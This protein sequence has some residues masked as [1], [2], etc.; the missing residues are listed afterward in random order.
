MNKIYD[1]IDLKKNLKNKKFTLVHGVFDI[2]H[3]GHKRHLDVAS[4]LSDYLVVSIT[5]DKYV[6]KGP[7]RPVFKDVQ[8]AEMIS[9]FSNVDYVYIN[10]DETPIKLINQIKPNVYCKGQDYKNSEDDITGNIKKE[11]NAIKKNGGKVHFT[12]EIQYSSSKII[13]QHLNNSKVL[14]ELKNKN[15]NLSKFKQQIE[16]YL[17]KAKSLKVAVIGELILDEYLYSINL[18]QPSKENIHAVEK[19]RSELFLGGSYA[20]A[21]NISEFCKQVDLISAF[22]VDK[23]LNQ[24][25][26]SDKKIKMRIVNLDKNFSLIKK[27]RYID[28]NYRKLFESYSYNGKKNNLK[29]NKKTQNYLV[30]NLTKYDCVIM[31]DFGHGFFSQEIYKKIIQHSS[32]LCLNVQTNA[33][34]R[35]F[36]L[37]TKYKK[38]DYLQL[39]LPELQL[40]TSDNR[41]SVEELVELILKKISPKY[42]VVTKGKDGIYLKNIKNNKQ[43]SLSAFETQPIDTMGAGDAVFGISSLLIKLAAPENVVAYLSNL[44]G[45]LATSIVGHSSYIKEK[46]IEKA[47]IYNLK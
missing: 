18:R 41:Q 22:K 23:E 4:T 30:K 36:N 16:Y 19:I 45:A 40:A 21:K 5:S 33:G 13:N 43:F 35:G 39:D 12:S 31:T 44:F 20:V 15:T 29:F 47:L 3:V 28:I 7:G 6:K 8:R 24:K 9:S 42:L 37:A 10:H 17:H 14:K 26:K 38:A 25:I 11:I 32:F 46:E 2:I 27:S 34:N 1:L